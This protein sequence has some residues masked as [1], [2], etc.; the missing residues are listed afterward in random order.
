ILGDFRE[1]AI[2]DLESDRRLE[3]PSHK[4]WRLPQDE[5]YPSPE[6]GSIGD[7]EDQDRPAEFVMRAIR[8]RRGQPAFRNAL[9]ERY[10]DRC[11]ITGCPVLDVLEAAHIRPYRTEAD[12]APDNGLL[13]RAYL[14]TLF[15]LDLL[16]IEPQTLTI[17]LHPRVAQAFS[18]DRQRLGVNGH[19]LDQSA[20]EARWE[21]FQARLKES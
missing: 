1:T 16:G 2:S 12:N 21:L 9:R 10:G 15:D 17:H 5:P 4:G 20:L 14:H 7:G 11:Q 13:L 19:Q 8:A 18:L 6:D 3:N